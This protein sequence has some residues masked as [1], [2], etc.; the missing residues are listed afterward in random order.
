[1]GVKPITIDNGHNPVQLLT[2][3]GGKVKPSQFQ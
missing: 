3:S 1:M 2:I